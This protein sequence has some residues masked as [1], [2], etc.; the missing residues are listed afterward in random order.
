MAAPLTPDAV[1]MIL[2]G[3]LDLKPVVQ[4]T[5]MADE[6]CGTAVSTSALTQLDVHR[7][8]AYARQL[9]CSHWS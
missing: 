8:Q 5:G 1:G 7:C 2:G 9:C 3:N 6:T 4:C